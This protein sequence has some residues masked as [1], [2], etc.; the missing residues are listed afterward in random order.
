MTEPK[1]VNLDSQPITVR[2]PS[3]HM[4][5]V[6]PFRELA[7]FHWRTEEDCVC[8]GQHYAKFP[9]LLSPFPE[10]EQKAAQP[11]QA[12]AGGAGV[13]AAA[14][15]GRYKATG[16]VLRPDGSIKKDA[17]ARDDAAG[18]QVDAG[19]DE[20][21]DG[22][23]GNESEDAAEGGEEDEQQDRPL[24]DVPGVSKALAVALRKAG[25]ASAVALANVQDEKSLAKL[26]KVKGVKDAGTL[27][28]AAQTL[29]GWE[30]VTEED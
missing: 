5:I 26:S 11:V 13:A 10:P 19:R 2:D 7:V 20:E 9:G 6:R 23:D 15:T 8:V 21:V 17:E 30:E 12:A 29:L 27:V 18:S 3:G 14:Q 4:R 24:E 28:D 16:D 1:F 22:E 25:Y